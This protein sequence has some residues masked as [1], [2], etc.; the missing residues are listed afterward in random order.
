MTPYPLATPLCVTTAV[1][2]LF[3]RSG[4]EMDGPCVIQLPTH[5]KGRHTSHGRYSSGAISGPSVGVKGL[6]SHFPVFL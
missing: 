5:L 2:P 4:C 6:S 3:R 1:S